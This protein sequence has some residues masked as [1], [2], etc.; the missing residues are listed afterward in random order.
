LTTRFAGSQG[1]ELS[2]QLD[3][4]AGSVRA[5]AL[6]VHCFA[7][8]AD[9]DAAK[10]ISTEL[11]RR[12]IAVLHF[13][14]SGLVRL[15][16]EAGAND[17]ASNVQDVVLAAAH[18]RKHFSAPA[19]LIGH[20]LG[21]AAVLAA[22]GLI[23]EARAVATIGAPADAQHILRLR[24]RSPG[25]TTAEGANQIAIAGRSFDVSPQFIADVQ[26]QKLH[27]AIAHMRKAL[28]VMHSPL[29]GEIGIDNASAIFVAAKHPKSFISLDHADHLLS[30]SAD[31]AYAASVLAAWSDRYVPT[32]GA[33]EATHDHVFVSET[34]LGKFQ[35]NVTAAQHR[36]LSDEP[37][38]V[39]GKDTGPTPYDFLSAA[40]GTCTSMTLR[41]YAD[42]KKLPLGRISVAVSH[43]KVAIDHCEDC[44]GAAEGRTGKIDRFV[45][46]IRIDGELAPELREKLE[47]IAGKCPVHRTL[48]HSSA[49]VTRVVDA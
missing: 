48:E 7:C 42:H 17:A 4:P 8:A 25:G 6:F 37:V 21:G 43:G 23:P 27:D 46:E 18:L 31:A 32:T 47:E 38:S 1:E 11:T 45:R 24:S 2:A 30:T 5:Y 10:H 12:G 41:M 49:V 13:D 3:L 16:G 35:N 33:S 29:D 19:I 39:G 26:S 34:G 22:A 9:P 40:L 20:S 15:R 36:M 44:G 14:F 28:L